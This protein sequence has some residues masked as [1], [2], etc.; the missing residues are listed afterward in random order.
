M[1]G[2]FWILIKQFVLKED[3]NWEWDAVFRQQSNGSTGFEYLFIEVPN[4]E[5]DDKKY[6]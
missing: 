4:I 5:N 3:G 2:Q 1:A 6:S